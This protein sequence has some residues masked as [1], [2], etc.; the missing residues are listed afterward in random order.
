MPRKGS[1]RICDEEWGWLIKV[2]YLDGMSHML[3]KSRLKVVWEKTGTVVKPYSKS[4]LSRHLK[5]ILDGLTEEDYRYMEA[6]GSELV[7]S[8]SGLTIRNPEYSTKYDYG[9]LS[10]EE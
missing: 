2:M 8:P 10:L 3:V 1:C 5:H 7:D 4:M 9:A 6:I